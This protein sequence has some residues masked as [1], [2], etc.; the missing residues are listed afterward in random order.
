MQLSPSPSLEEMGSPWG[1]TS[2]AAQANVVL[3]WRAHVLN[4]NPDP[5]PGLCRNAP[6]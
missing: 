5:G 4:L 1:A 2:I 6:S 3:M